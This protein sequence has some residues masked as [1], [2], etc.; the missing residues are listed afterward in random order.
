MRLTIVISF[1]FLISCNSSESPT[2][3]WAAQKNRFS[4]QNK[5]E[6]GNDRAIQADFKRL[7]K[8]NH[9]IFDTLVPDGVYLYSWQER[10][11]TK[12][13]FTVVS[14]DG[15]YGWRLFYVILDKND[16]LISAE[17]IAEKQIEGNLW[18]V[19]K[20]WF[21]SKDTIRTLRSLAEGYD[22]KT[23]LS[24]APNPAYSE[25]YVFEKNGKLQGYIL[26]NLDKLPVEDK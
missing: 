4:Y 12:N 25:Y 8:S 18:F 22:I 17:R 20:A 7:K 21:A 9:A 15:R 2:S 19:K 26:Y 1:I 13:E 24:F 11:P 14:D 16:K 6:F 5:T 23:R 3:Y 10:D